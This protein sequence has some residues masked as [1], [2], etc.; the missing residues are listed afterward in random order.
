MAIFWLF[1]KRKEIKKAFSKI[2]L[3]A[4]FLLFLFLGIMQS[5]S[6][7]AGLYGLIKL[8]EYIILFSYT[9]KNFRKLSSGILLSTFITGILLESFLTVAQYINQGAIGGAFYLLGERTFNAQTPGIAN[10]S[11]NGQLFLRPYATFSHPN[12]LAGYLFIFMSLV[13][14]YSRTRFFKHQN[15]FVYFSLVCGSIALFLTMGRVA[16]FAWALF[17]ISL[18]A[19]SFWKKTRMDSSKKGYLH[20]LKNKTII[21]ITLTAVVFIL[22]FPAGLRL[23]QFNLSDRSIVQ[24]EQ[25]AKDSFAMFQENPALGVGLNNFL[26]NV[27]DIQKENKEDLLIQPVHNIYLLVLSQTGIIGLIFSLYFIIKT[28]KVSEKITNIELPVL[29]LLILILGLFDHYLLT[30]QQGQI[31]LTIIVGLLWSTSDTPG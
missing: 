1:E 30:L 18:T 14:L 19:H 31:M 28:F 23:F 2:Q 26:V 8:L 22:T 29:F 11:I 7:D 12:I 20:I 3:T 9:A 27:A 15:V 4:V 21:L 25:L 24:R 6:P 5:N 16:I 13:V 10:A 17:L